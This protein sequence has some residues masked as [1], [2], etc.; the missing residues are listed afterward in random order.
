MILLQKFISEAQLKLKN[1]KIL[2][3]IESNSAKIIR[4]GQKL[5]EL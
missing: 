4:F 2:T 5:S 3:L 1:S